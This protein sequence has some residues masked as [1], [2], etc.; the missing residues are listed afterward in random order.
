MREADVGAGVI[1]AVGDGST[2]GSG[3]TTS[4]PQAVSATSIATEHKT[5]IVFTI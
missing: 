3:V 2:V 1:V 4:P 5:K